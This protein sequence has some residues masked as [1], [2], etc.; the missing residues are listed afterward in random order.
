[1]H[2][3]RD[4]RKRAQHSPL[5]S[6][7]EST[8]VPSCLSGWRWRQYQLDLNTFSSLYGYKQGLEFF[9]PSAVTAET[10]LDSSERCSYKESKKDAPIPQSESSKGSRV[11]LQANS[12]SV[13]SNWS[14][15]DGPSPRSTL[16]SV[17][18]SLAGARGSD[19]ARRNSEGRWLRRATYLVCCV[20]GQVQY[21]RICEH[22]DSGK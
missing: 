22:V 12:S 1:M 16:I 10:S 11:K 6:R 5:P 17:I 15:K 9:L 13:C 19:L 3:F 7:S 21:V 8:H 2:L 14:I 18:A 4:M 20:V